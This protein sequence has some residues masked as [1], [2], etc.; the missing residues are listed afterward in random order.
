MCTNP[1]CVLNVEAGLKPRFI[2]TGDE[3]R[4]LYCESI[5]K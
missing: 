5:V 1:R 3:H 4:C 2:K